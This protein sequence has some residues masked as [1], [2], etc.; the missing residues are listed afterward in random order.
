VTATLQPGDRVVSLLRTPA[1]VIGE[2]TTSD[3]HQRIQVRLDDG[4]VCDYPP[5]LLRPKE[6]DEHEPRY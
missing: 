5:M 4:R 3:G 1:V 2:R 6:P